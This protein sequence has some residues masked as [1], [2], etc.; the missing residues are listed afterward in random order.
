MANGLHRQID[1]ER[2]PIEMVLGKPLD[3]RQCTN[4]RVSEPRELLEGNKQFFV[5]EQ[6]PKTVLRYV[7]DFSY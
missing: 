4:R 6:Q 5:A 2:R 1:V 7:R 3:F